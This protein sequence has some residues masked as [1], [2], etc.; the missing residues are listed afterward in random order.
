MKKALLA[1]LSILFLV[2]CGESES[3]TNANG[4]D[5]EEIEITEENVEDAIEEVQEIDTSEDVDSLEVDIEEGVS[6]DR[7]INDVTTIDIEEL[8]RDFEYN[9][10]GAGDEISHFSIEDGVIKVTITQEEHDLLSLEDLVVAG[11]SAAGDFLL[12]YDGW[13]VLTIDY[14]AVG[15]VSMNRSEKESNEYGDY[16]PILSI[17][18]KLGITY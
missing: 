12:E 2:A 11:Y 1:L 14:P 13:D 9:V 15:E 6:I 17:E 3:E 5:Q 10:L 4:S 18:E 7:D 16:F 8:K